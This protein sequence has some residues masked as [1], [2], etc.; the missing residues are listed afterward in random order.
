MRPRDFSGRRDFLNPQAVA[1]TT[2]GIVIVII[3]VVAGVGVGLFYATQP[4]TSSTTTAATSAAFRDTLIIDEAFWPGND[5]NPLANVLYLWGS[6][7]KLYTVYQSLLTL[8]GTLLYKTGDIQLLPM[9]A[10]DWSASP[11]ATVYTFNLRQ[12]VTF[13]NGD[14][15]NAYQ[16]WAQWYC[17]YYFLGNASNFLNGYSIFDFSNVQ[18][19]PATLSLMTQSGV[20]NPNPELMSIMM[21]KTWPI[22][23]TGPYQIVLHLKAPFR[24]LPSLLTVFGGLVLDTQYILSNGGFGTSGTPNSYFNQHSIPGTGPYVIAAFQS[25]SYMK[26]TQN[27]TYWGA[28][29]TPAEIQANP[30]L[31]PGHAKNVIIYAK[32]DDVTRY[33]DLSTGAVQI[34]SILQ[35]NWPLVLANPD[36]YSYYTMPANGAILEGVGINTM[37]YPTNITAFRQAIV[38]AINYTDVNQKV[39]FGTLTPWMGPEAPAQKEFYALGNVAPYTYDPESA[40]NYLTQ[41][42]VD[43]AKLEPLQLTVAA[44]CTGCIAA[45]QVIQADLAQLGITLSVN[46]IPLSSW[47]VPQVS[48]AGPYESS[49]AMSSQEPHF[50][51]M[52]FPTLVGL[53]NPLDTWLML[54]NYHAPTNDYANYAN[55]VV[56]K[57]VDAFTSTNDLDYIK[58][59]CTAAQAQYYNDAP[60]IWLGTC[61]LAFG[62]GSL[63]WDK[64]VVGSFLMDPGFTTES[65]TA[66]FNTVTFVS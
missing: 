38:H 27:P 56:Q 3:V 4:S 52:G 15:F 10:T 64:S 48:G 8:N 23:V 20:V 60:Y 63:V 57:C 6:D 19:G 46:V 58:Q 21:D 11:D 34:S 61:T 9:L 16:V 37:R 41:S 14:P 29:L 25:G 47:G 62:S 51:W 39:Y 50:T 31:D 36:K 65:T 55:P 22:Y 26:F 42:G 59:V 35:Q 13:S 17:S 43:V 24:W 30:Y 18:F 28:N 33:T 12:G 2:A 7:Y 1:K 45:A 66:I 54:G 32:S 53:A 5:L 49:V 40:K 44:G